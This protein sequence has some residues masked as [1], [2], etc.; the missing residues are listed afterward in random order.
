MMLLCD[1]ITLKN[2]NPNIIEDVKSIGKI[3]EI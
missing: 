3:I 1:C 2:F